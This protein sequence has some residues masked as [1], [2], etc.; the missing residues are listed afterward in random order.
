MFYHRLSEKSLWFIHIRNSQVFLPFIICRCAQMSVNGFGQ[1]V[2]IW[3]QSCSKFLIGWES[4]GSYVFYVAYVQLFHIS[5]ADVHDCCEMHTAHIPCSNYA[6]ETWITIKLH[7]TRTTITHGSCSTLTYLFF[8][9]FVLLL[10]FWCY[11]SVLNLL[12]FLMKNHDISHFF[13]YFTYDIH[14]WT[15]CK[16]C[17]GAVWQ[18]LKTAVMFNTDNQTYWS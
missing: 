8:G 9:L 11:S 10:V 5:Y 15:I 17:V 4:C 3:I 7:L 1:W 18:D 2:F 12:K 14:L 16:M 6:I 13:A